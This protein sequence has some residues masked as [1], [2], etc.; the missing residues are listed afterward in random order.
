MIF[1]DGIVIYN[2]K[3]VLY[4]P[5]LY[6]LQILEKVEQSQGYDFDRMSMKTGETKMPLVVAE[7][8]FA[9]AVSMSIVCAVLMS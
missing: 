1:E 9:S 3:K 5:K 4:F 7:T 2:D 8:K 6:D